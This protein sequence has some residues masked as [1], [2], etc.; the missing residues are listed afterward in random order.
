MTSDGQV[1]ARATLAQTPHSASETLA[2]PADVEDNP[3]IGQR[4][5]SQ[6]DGTIVE[7]AGTAV[8]L[9]QH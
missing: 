6:H 8:L 9:V 5:D 2:P 1:S 7:W 3:H 4:E